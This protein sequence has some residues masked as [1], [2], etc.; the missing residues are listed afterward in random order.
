[1]ALLLTGCSSDQL[2]SPVSAPD[3]V[4]SATVTPEPGTTLEEVDSTAVDAGQVLLR[5]TDR[6]AS[7]HLDM[8][9]ITCFFGGRY[10][11][12]EQDGRIVS[13]D[14]P[15]IDG[16]PFPDGW[17]LSEVLARVIAEPDGYSLRVSAD[18]TSVSLDADPEPA[19]IDDEFTY[20]VLDL[21]L[22]DRVVG[23]RDGEADCRDRGEEDLD[24]D[25]EPL[26]WRANTQVTFTR[27]GCAVRVDV[28]GGWW[29][30]DHCGTQYVEAIMSGPTLGQPRTGV[31]DTHYY[32]KDP[33]DVLGLAED[34]EA[35]TTLGPDAVDTGYR[36]GFRQIWLVPGDDAAIYVVDFDQ[37]QRWPSAASIPA[38]D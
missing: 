5:L 8:S 12:Q 21:V 20:Q 19:A 29:G 30:S 33:N 10:E 37:V 32:V 23:L 18:G 26:S 25:A 22:T 4:P 36:N 7:Y 35:W 17:S 28:L 14:P 34:F 15:A 11:V 13:V 24:L 2:D 31:A 6:R 9:C 27:D 3:S 38:C 1:M 16:Q